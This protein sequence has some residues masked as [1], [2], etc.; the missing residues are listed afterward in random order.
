MSLLSG[1]LPSK[2]GVFSNAGALPQDTTT[3]LHSLGAAGYETVLCGRMHFEG[4]DQRHGFTRRIAG[5]ITPLYHGYRKNALAERGPF[6]E[7]LTEKGCLQIIGGGNSPTLEYDRYVIRAALDYLNQ[8][9]EK[10]QCIVV[11]TYGPHFPYVAPPELFNYYHDKVSLPNPAGSYD[12]YHPVTTSLAQRA[13]DTILRAVRAAYWGMVEN[14]DAQIGAVYDKWQD[15]L[16]IS[17]REGIFLYF[18]DHGDQTGERGIFG[19][20]TFYE[21]S[22][23]IPMIWNGAGIFQ[24]RIVQSPVSIIDIGPTLCDLTD[25][26]PPP[27][28]E[29]ESLLRDLSG[30]GENKERWVTS[31]YMAS[32]NNHCI[33]ARMLRWQNWKFITYYGYEKY[34][35]LFDLKSDPGDLKNI[36]AKKPQLLEMAGR[37]ARKGWNPQLLV[38]NHI[39]HLEHMKLYR[40]WAANCVLDEAERWKCT[41][42]AARPPENYVSGADR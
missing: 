36:A 35:L 7:T 29:G 9:H 25:A 34:D 32:L 2:T 38:Q 1:R 13:S 12:Y 39:T 24:D 5:D 42:E 16:K 6:A 23:H 21:N 28:Q 33:P 8:K 19:K 41:P 4:N 17:D 26:P 3:F 18:S 15:Y 22:A 11:G 10:P 31:E 30:L 40:D 20:S 37:R 27:K 14:M